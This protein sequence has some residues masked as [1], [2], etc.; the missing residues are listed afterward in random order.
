M[1]TTLNGGIDDIGRIS[2]FGVR[3]D[4]IAADTRS[5]EQ[6]LDVVVQPFGFI[7]TSWTSAVSFFSF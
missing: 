6:V 2:P 7:A 4:A 1:T 5:V 3:L